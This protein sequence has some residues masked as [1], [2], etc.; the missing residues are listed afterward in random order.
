MLIVHS[1]SSSSPQKKQRVFPACVSVY[2]VCAWCPPRTEVAANS[3]RSG[4]IAGYE[5]EIEPRPSGRSATALN[6]EPSFP[7]PNYS[8]RTKQE[9]KSHFLPLGYVE[10]PGSLGHNVLLEASGLMLVS[11]GTS[12]EDPVKV[13]GAWPRHLQTSLA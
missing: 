4:V 13:F 9:V 10:I 8:S 12:C 1:V 7:S 3:A 11:T 6:P 2:H 5:L